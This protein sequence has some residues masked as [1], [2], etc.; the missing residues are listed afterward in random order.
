MLTHAGADTLWWLLLALSLAN[1][2]LVGRYGTLLREALTRM[3]A[4]L[5]IRISP[6]VVQK[7]HDLPQVIL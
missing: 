6:Y 4:I 7:L 5:K 1:L 3:P 2:E